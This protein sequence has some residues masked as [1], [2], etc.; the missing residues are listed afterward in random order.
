MQRINIPCHARPET[1]QSRSPVALVAVSNPYGVDVRTHARPI[2][3]QQAAKRIRAVARV[4]RIRVSRV[5]MV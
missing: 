5:F 4:R 1:I 3:Q 2:E